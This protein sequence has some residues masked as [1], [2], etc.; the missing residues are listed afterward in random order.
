VPQRPDDPRRVLLISHDVVGGTMAGPGIRYSHLA[1]VLARYLGVTLAIPEESP[2]ETDA[3][4]FAMSRYRRQDWTSIEPLIHDASVV[5]CPSDIVSD[6]PRLTQSGAFLVVDG[7]DP[8]LAEWLALS[9]SGDIETQRP[10]WWRRMCELNQQY[11][12][13]DFYIC[14]SER[15]RDWWLG[16]LEAN[17]RINPW[18]FGQDL[19]L[20]ELVA[21]VPYGLPEVP[22]QRTRQILKG[23]RPGIGADDRVILWGGGLWP[24]LDP[25]TAVRA[26]GRLWSTRQDVRLIFPGTVHPD[27]WMEKMPTHIAA[28][29][30]AAA[31]M[32]LLDRAVFFT[33]WLP[34]ADWPNVLLESDVAL[35][36]GLDTLETRFAFRSR[37]L[38][39]IWAG[40]PIVTTRGDA[41]SDLVAEYGLG[42][43]VDYQDVAGTAAAIGRLL[44]TPREAWQPGFQQV[45]ADF[46]WERVAQ[47][48]IQFCLHPWRAADKEALGDE[49]GAPFYLEEQNRLRQDRDYWRDVAE[50]YE[51]GRFMRVMRQVHRWRQ[52]FQRGTGHSLG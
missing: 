12:A 38:E 39:Y 36:L 6:F 27:P 16:L 51:R 18:T 15:Q 26:I 40:L 17:G 2:A 5:I 29:R 37:V 24:W 35:A 48:L 11:L 47:P 49:V 44:E 50:R 3:D 20:R 19:A 41:C 31:Q 34:Y 7:Y 9:A 10:G 45:R 8:L 22:P 25:V 23:V 33:E 32:G 42:Q 28:T 1:R 46:T 30:E 21:V 43:A 13:G 4:S 52:R 14:A